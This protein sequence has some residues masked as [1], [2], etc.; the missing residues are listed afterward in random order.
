MLWS[1]TLKVK[2]CTYTRNLKCLNYKTKH[3]LLVNKGGKN[4]IC[5][6]TTFLVVL[7]PYCWSYVIY[8]CNSVCIYVYMYTYTCIYIIALFHYGGHSINIKVKETQA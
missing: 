6:S 1:G 3:V 8:I 7:R 4:D 5:I 2:K